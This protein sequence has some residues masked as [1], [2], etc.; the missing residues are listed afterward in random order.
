MDYEGKTASN[1]K[2]CVFFKAM[3]YIDL[4]Y[5]SQKCQLKL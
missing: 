2:T 3:T 4:L 1:M 5:I